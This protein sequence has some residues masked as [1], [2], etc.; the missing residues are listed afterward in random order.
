MAQKRL[1][2]VGL[3]GMLVVLGMGS[4]ALAAPEAS[5]PVGTA[6]GELQKAF[7][8]VARRVGPAVVSIAVEHT[9]HLQARRFGFGGGGPEDEFFDRFFSDFFSQ[10]P[11]REF[12][13]RGLGSGVIIDPEGYILTNEHVVGGADKLVVTLPDGREFKAVV[14]GT[15]PMADLAVVKIQAKDLPVAELGDSNTVQ[16]GQWAIAIGN[17]FGYAVGSSEP[18]VT[19]GVISAL[20][21]S[22]RA[23]RERNY[24]GLIQTDAAINPGN[25]GGPLVDL[26]GKVIGIN[27]AIFSTS[28][29][30]QGIGFAIPSNTARAIVGD[31]IKGKKVLYGWLGVNVQDLDEGLAGYFGTPDRNGVV[32]ARVLPGGPAEKAGVKDGD[33]I[34]GYQSQPIRN[35]RELLGAVARTKVGATVTLDLL[36]E[37]K[38]LKV[39]VNVSERPSDLA[40]SAERASATWRGLSVSALTEELARQFRLADRRGVVVTQVEPGSPADEAGLRPGDVI[41]EINRRPI[42]TLDDYARAIA[43]VTGDCLVRTLRGYAIVHAPKE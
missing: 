19:V 43:G 23:D 39:T 16:I 10:M 27:V 35:V 33:V 41:N 26:S 31:L 2:S 22:I 11:E 3:I 38:T 20:N 7:I 34:R 13:S 18:T 28:G 4:A 40:G 9:E 6:A 42:A 14:K 1:L 12:K 24:P 37:K 17:P 32:V 36:R 21:R 5:A 15:D 30:Y 25:S 8:D 29:G